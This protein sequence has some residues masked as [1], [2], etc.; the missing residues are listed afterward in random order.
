MRNNIALYRCMLL[1]LCFNL[2]TNL[3]SYNQRT[4][5]LIADKAPHATITTLRGKTFSLR[6]ISCA[7]ES[8]ALTVYTAPNNTKKIVSLLDYNPKPTARTL[9]LTDIAY[10]N[11]PYPYAVWY[12]NRHTGLRKHDKYL[13]IEVTLQ[14][15][16]HATP[17]NYLIRH[18]LRIHG[19]QG[20]AESE[21]QSSFALRA[22]KK[23]QFYH[24]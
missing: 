22:I 6:S 7:R 23:I 2:F 4:R 14:T 17:F 19:L 15:D 24:T 18:K 5:S 8:D 9:S 1:T 10:I 21:T 13:L 20:T 12:Y 11:I 16:P 3:T